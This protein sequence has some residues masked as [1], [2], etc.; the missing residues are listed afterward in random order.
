[1]NCHE[2][3]TQ[4]SEYLDGALDPLRTKSIESHLLA[5]PVCRAETDGL[6]D[7]I[8]QVAQLP[9]VDPPPG[10]AQRVMAHARAME[11]EP[12]L[13]QKIIAPLRFSVPVQ[14]SAAVLIA[15][16]AVLIY[17]NESPLKNDPS[18]P[19]MPTATAPSTDRPSAD[20]ETPLRAT[21]PKAKLDSER[22]RVAEK[23]P[24]RSEPAISA[25][26]ESAAQAAAKAEVASAVGELRDLPHRA[27]I[28]A[29]E[30]AT[31]SENVRPDA[32]PFGFGPSL[33]PP[34]RPGLF[35]PDRLLSPLSEPSAD[36]EFVV[37]RREG[38]PKKAAEARRAEADSRAVGALAKR[39]SEPATP[40][41]NSMT[42]VKWFTV[43][44]ERYDQFKKELAAEAT[45]DSERPI[46]SMTNDLSARPNRDLLIKV[47]V[48]TP[49]ER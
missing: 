13:W 44:A 4:L 48:L 18:A 34:F 38:E 28:Q 40:Q 19:S 12:S 39:S 23:A 31:G 7:C 45:I 10:F 16:L 21:A 29:Q 37:R 47:I 41:P 46:G 43:P 5:C 33:N 30:I 3:Q 22:L 9:A 42:E 1:M 24:A 36:V 25:S 26:K 2:A 8:R 20:S 17:Q 14:A 32:N 49:L 35:A 6:A 15:V 11:V 27:P